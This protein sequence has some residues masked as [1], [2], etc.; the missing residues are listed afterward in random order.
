MP[1]APA[2]Y[3]PGLP[4]TIEAIE[5]GCIPRLS[6]DAQGRRTESPRAIELPR[7]GGGK[8][9][10]FC[11]NLSFVVGASGGEETTWVYVEWAIGGEVHGRP[12][13]LDELTQGKGYKT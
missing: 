13:T 3:A 2:R 11:L 1:K 12:I 5:M 10:R 9:R 7:A 8:V 4:Q 6:T